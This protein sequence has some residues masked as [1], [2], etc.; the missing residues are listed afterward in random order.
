MHVEVNEAQLNESFRVLNG[1]QIDM[2]CL[3]TDAAE[4]VDY[5]SSFEIQECQKHF[6]APDR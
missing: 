1:I 4:I 2:P 3:V 6:I 5:D